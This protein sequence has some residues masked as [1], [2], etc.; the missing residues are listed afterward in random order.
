MCAIN[1]ASGNKV[2]LVTEMNRI[3]AYRGPDTTKVVADEHFTLGHNRLAIIDLKPEAA[4]PMQDREETLEIVFN[5]EIYNYLD[6]KRQ[7]IGFYQFQTDSD[8]EV[9]LAAYK[10]WGKDCVKKLNGIFAFAIYDK[11]ASELFL[12]RDPIGVKPLYYYHNGSDFLFSSEIKALFALQEIPHTVNI[13]ALNHYLRVLYVPEPLTMF[14]HICKLPA[15]S[16]AVFTSG[17]LTVTPYETEIVS[18]ATDTNTETLRG[19][20][21]Q[22]VKRQLVS[23]RPVGIY[24]SGGIDSSVVLHSVAKVRSNIDTFTVGFE[25][26]KEEESEKFNADFELARKTAAHYKTNHHEVILK[27]GEVQTLLEQAVYHLDEPIANPTVIPMLKLAELAHEHV[28]VTLGGDGG[29]ELFGG[30]ERYRLSLAASYYQKIPKFIRALFPKT[31][32]LRKLATRAGIDRFALFMFQKEPVLDQV[33]TP[34]FHTE[35]PYAFFSQFF[36]ET[37][38]DFESKLME[39]DRKTWLRDE[40]LLRSDKMSMAHSIEARVPLLDLELVDFAKRLPRSR[41]VS[42]S[43]TKIAFKEAFRGSIPEYLFDQ[44]KRGW[45]SPGAKWLRRADIERFAREVLSPSYHTGTVELFNFDGVIHM[46]DRHISKEEYN[47]NMLWALIFFQLWA[48]RFNASL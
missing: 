41:K 11:G 29:D 16:T 48:K 12:A 46:L 37:A 32:A 13:D 36:T 28:V 1:G 19:V 44:P 31:D 2:A 4:Q 38:P 40:S 15:G 33:L 23:D 3:L 18:V 34:R 6:L 5:G 30:Y 27:E 10:K 25:L 26:S 22:A 20:V 8:T 24:L 17:V 9:I 21:E 35:A 47:S 43:N 7:L 45:F 39:V 42:L 14:Q